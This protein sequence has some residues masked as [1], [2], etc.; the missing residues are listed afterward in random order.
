MS[1][2][3]ISGYESATNYTLFAP[4]GL[5]RDIV[6]RLNRESNAAL[7]MADVR[8]KLLSLGIVVAGGSVDAVEK[9][10]PSEMEKWARVIKSANLKFD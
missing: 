3:G 8:E 5:A 10:V 4:A 7:Q 6:D 1:E 2:A 9:R